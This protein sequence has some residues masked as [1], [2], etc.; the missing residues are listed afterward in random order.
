MIVSAITLVVVSKLAKYVFANKYLDAKWD[1]LE[2]NLANGGRSFI[3]KNMNAEGFEDEKSHTNLA[4]ETYAQQ[5]EKK[6]FDN[7]AFTK[8]FSTKL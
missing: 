7:S 8:D 4:L 5:T 3:N 6:S 2:C 1:V